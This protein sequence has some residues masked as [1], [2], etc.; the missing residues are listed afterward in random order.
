MKTPAD[1]SPEPQRQAAAHQAPQQQD[2][3]DAELQF[4]DN[5]AETANLR[6]LQAAADNSPQAQG[7]S[8]LSAMMT[9]SPRSGAM[10]SLQAMVDNSPRRAS[11]V[12]QA[13]SGDALVQRVEDEEVLQGEFAAESPAQLAQPPEDK[14]NNTGLPDNLKVGVESLSGLSLDNVKVHYNSSKPAQL[15]AHA[16]A[17]GTDIHLG[18]GQEQHLPHEA[19]HVVQQAQGRV[20]PTVQMKDGVSVNDDRGL[21]A[22]ADLMGARAVSAGGVKEKSASIESDPIGFNVNDDK[23]LEKEADIIGTESMQMRRSEKSAFEFPTLSTHIEAPIRQPLKSPV[24]RTLHGHVDAAGHRHDFETYILGYLNAY[25]ANNIVIGA[26]VAPAHGA[27]PAVIV[28]IPTWLGAI[29][30]A[31][32]LDTRHPRQAANLDPQYGHPSTLL[33]PIPGGVAVPGVGGGTRLNEMNAIRNF[34]I[35]ASGHAGAGAGVNAAGQQNSVINWGGLHNGFGTK[36]EATLLPGG[37][38]K[39]SEPSLLGGHAAWNNLGRRK[40][41][42]GTQLYAAGHLLHDRLGGPGLDYNLTPLTNATNGGFGAN[43]ANLAHRQEVEG[44]L[45]DAYNDMHAGAR[46]ITQVN[47][48]VIANYTRGARPE[49]AIVQ[50]IANTYSARINGHV[51][52]VAPTHAQV[53]AGMVAA[54]VGIIPAPAN[55]LND[56]MAA[57]AAIYPPGVA[58]TNNTPAVLVWGQLNLNATLWQLEDQRVP[59]QL[60]IRYNWIENGIAKAVRN[61]TIAN[62]LPDSVRAPIG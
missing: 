16:Y 6:Q 59:L 54:L 35:F 13:V 17:Q 15:N 39:G 14:P 31:R 34:V 50:A 7:L 52:V 46:N 53:M 9:N 11:M 49:T 36:V 5:R 22:E 27:Q 38:P 40:R 4:I 44:A 25:I 10:Q 58:A 60:D 26:P 21:E 8:Q 3:T 29:R 20:R 32:I 41:A 28:G 62:D 33:N 19:W 51:G 12:S 55:H 37:Q 18:P 56:A 61:R 45:L 42:D 24:Q 43:N 48:M 47:Y 2:N 30:A 23:G 1:K 57:I